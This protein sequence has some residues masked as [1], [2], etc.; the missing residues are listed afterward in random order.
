[1]RCIACHTETF[2]SLPIQPRGMMSDGRIVE[3]PLSKEQCVECGL[4]R[5]TSPLSQDDIIAL[6]Q[7][8]YGLPSAAP[9]ADFARAEAYCRVICSALPVAFKPKHIL[10]I[11]SGSGALVRAL[12]SALATTHVYGVD[13]AGSEEKGDGFTLKTGFFEAHQN[14]ITECELIISVNTLEHVADPIGTIAGFTENLS[15]DGVVVLICPT[16]APSNVE[17]LFDDHIWSYSPK[18]FAA[19]ARNAGLTLQ[20]WQRLPRSFG[21]FQMI[22][23]RRE[24]QISASFEPPND[25]GTPEA[26]LASW[27]QLDGSIMEDLGDRS[28]S[29]FGAGQMAALMRCYA[30]RV[31]A[32]TK[33]LIMDNP[34]TS[35]SL[36][37][38]GPVPE[39]LSPDNPIVIAT[40]PRHHGALA[41]RIAKQGGCA[42]RFDDKI[43][44]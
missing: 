23:L 6:Y 27:L 30:P 7:T 5:H 16:S 40:H 9:E 19:V 36:G 41:A 10:D 11:G 24:G 18:A 25:R 21:D 33:S 22:I 44:R 28:C 26:Y 34:D 15:E 4:I 13:P 14:A 39:K 2:H 42:I 20:N 3:K 37:V 8:D 43:E 29:I 32:R 12:G 1:M 35:W 38:V 17:L 31:W